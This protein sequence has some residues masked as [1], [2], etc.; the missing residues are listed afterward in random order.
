MQVYFMYI[1]IFNFVRNKGTYGSLIIPPLTKNL[2]KG[3]VGSLII[4]PLTKN[5]PKGTHGLPNDLRS[6][7]EL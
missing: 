4:P 7:H 1:C 2:P 3:T 6:F 5:C